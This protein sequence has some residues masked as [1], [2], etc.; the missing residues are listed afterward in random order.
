MATEKSF[1]ENLETEVQQAREEFI[2]AQDKYN[3]ARSEL[4]VGSNALKLSYYGEIPEDPQSRKTIIFTVI[5]YALG[6]AVTGFIILALEFLDQRLKNPI[7]FQRETKFEPTA[8]AS[9]LKNFDG[10]LSHVVEGE[11]PEVKEETASAFLQTFRKLRFEI[12]S[13]T[14]HTFLFTSL[15]EGS[16]KSF[17]IAALAHSLSLIERRVLIVDTNFKNNQ[18]SE[19]FKDISKANVEGGLDKLIQMSQKI[20][21]E[22]IARDKFIAAGIIPRTN[23]PY[24]DVIRN[25]QIKLSPSEVLFKI[26]FGQI[27]DKL[28]EEYQFIFLEGSS[29]NKYSDSEELTNFSEYLIPVFSVQDEFK[30][31]DKKS[32]QF[33]KQLKDRISAIVL[34]KV[35]E[36]DIS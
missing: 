21:D 35:L 3:K 27:M 30:E 24:V 25:D 36:D 32:L 16:G 31:T 13:L 7:K 26:K 28:S 33:I 6:L 12:Q 15:R 20:P 2:A 23:N 5:G 34:N 14:G 19:T 17:V 29:L 22:V 1:I 9:F 11:F 4:V 8:M 10:D 18:I